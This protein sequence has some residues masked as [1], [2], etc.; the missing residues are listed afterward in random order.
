MCGIAGIWVADKQ[1]APQ[2]STIEKLKKMAA[3]L[4]HRGPD[5]QGI[6][7]DRNLGLVHSRLSI[8]DLQG[9]DQPLFSADKQQVLIANGEIYNFIE[10]RKELVKKGCRF[11]THSDCEVLLQ[12][13]TVYGED[14]LRDI[15]GMFA[16]A[17]FD[18]QRDLLWLGRDRLGIK[19]LYISRQGNAWLFA[20][21]LKAL[22]AAMAHKPQLDPRGLA[23]FLQN[24]CCTGG[25]TVVAGVEK[26]MPGELIRFKRNGELHRRRYW[27]ALTV[28]PR[29]IDY[30]QAEQE[31]DAL[32]DRVMEHHMR[33]DVPFGLFLSGGVDSSIL[34]AKLSQLGS[35]AVRTYSVGFPGTDSTDELPAA[36]QLA[37]QFN[38]RHT[39]LPVSFDDIRKRMPYSVWCADDM[40]RDNASLPT[41]LLAQTAAEELKVVFSGEGGDEVFAGY[42]RYGARGPESWL[43]N[44]IRPGSGGF[45][46]RGDFRRFARGVFGD[47]LLAHSQ[48]FREPIVGAWRQ[49][50]PTWSSLQRQQYVDL[51]LALPDNLLV[52]ADRM[53]MGF[54]LE[55]RVPFLDHRVVAFG[56]SLPDTLK[57][58]AL[59]KKYFL[60]KWA[61]RWLPEQRLFSRKHGFI[62]PMQQWLQG[63]YLDRTEAQLLN[64]PAVREWFVTDGIRKLCQR[65]R[66]HGDSARMIWSIL[67]F[68]LWHR[69]F[70]DGDGSPP[71]LLAEPL[72]ILG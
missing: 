32:F 36:R 16:F 41:S 64:Q 67:H 72:D 26:V 43:K 65:Q 52:K 23:Q 25:G 12:A 15:D 13:Y 10:Y 39:E 51:S 8:I 6:Y 45:R 56:L 34:L 11:A 62:V 50:P 7:Q 2:Q 69:I 37:K 3:A 70:V 54:A 17:L 31:F 59:G 4:Q 28:K 58:Q 44:I 35:Q 60:K 61:S 42:G 66:R 48:A 18:K 20:S 63:D 71:P 49:C 40:M 1:Q 47:K 19:P 55:G 14:F 38:S 24:Q 57:I 46:T 27:S 33:A 5:A 22:F 9:G 53:L 30:P 68:A 29:D 21:E